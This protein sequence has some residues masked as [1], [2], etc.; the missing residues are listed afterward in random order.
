ME[1]ATK[2]VLTRRYTDTQ[3]LETYL[4]RWDT[5]W[6]TDEVEQ[7]PTF[8]TL[9]H[10]F[11]NLEKI[12][13]EGIPEPE[14]STEEGE[15]LLVWGEGTNRFF[16]RIDV[17]GLTATAIIADLSQRGYNTFTSSVK[18]K[19]DWLRIKREIEYEMGY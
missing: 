18:E 9:P 2:P 16:L 3:M 4:R 6:N 11:A 12:C 8:D 5:I 10:I 13:S 1:T 7:L 15:M 17:A 14:L 19:K